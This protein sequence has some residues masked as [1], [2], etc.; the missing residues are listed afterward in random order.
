MSKSTYSVNGRQR[1][2]LAFLCVG[3]LTGISFFINYKIQAETD[4][5]NL[6]SQKNNFA[7]KSFSAKRKSF[8]PV[9]IGERTSVWLKLQEGKPLDTMFHGSDAAISTL[10]S[11]L[12]EPTAQFSADINLDGHADLVSG[13]RNAA[14]GGLIALHRASRQAFEPTDEQVLADLRRGRFSGDV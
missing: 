6:Q 2:F 11:N 13:F 12:A 7:L 1:I 3:I 8:D 10:R 14:G 4:S 5:Q 9:N